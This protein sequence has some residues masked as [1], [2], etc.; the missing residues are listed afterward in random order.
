MFK[1]KTVDSVVASLSDMQQKLVE[2]AMVEH[3]KAVDLAEASKVAAT[4]A[5]RA[6]RIYKKIKDLLGD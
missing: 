5:A 6:D 2:V 1:Q 4:E 3:K